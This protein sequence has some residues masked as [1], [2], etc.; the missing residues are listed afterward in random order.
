[1]R[2]DCGSI[3]RWLA[4]SPF[5]LPAA[6]SS[7]SR[8]SVF[9]SSWRSKSSALAF[10]PTERHAGAPANLGRPVVHSLLATR[11]VG[12]LVPPKQ[13]FIRTVPPPS[14]P[15]GQGRQQRDR[16]ALRRIPGRVP[17]WWHISRTCPRSTMRR[18]GLARLGDGTDRQ[19][20]GARCALS[21]HLVR[22]GMYRSARACSG[23][24]RL[25]WAPHCKRARSAGEHHGATASYAESFRNFR[26]PRRCWHPRPTFRGDPARRR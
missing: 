8:A 1:M 18:I 4:R 2:I 15:R 5:P 14:A 24:A 26:P 7:A 23:G 25:G 21:G 3:P 16:T 13:E 20:A 6:R 11:P 12:S 22:R 10:L 19:V 17:I 9:E